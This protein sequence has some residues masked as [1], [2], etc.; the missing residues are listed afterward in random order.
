[1]LLCDIGNTSYHFFDDATGIDYREAVAAFDPASLSET[2]FYINVNADV[3]PR[4][5]ALAPWRDLEPAI[6]RR[7]YY[8]SMGIDR[9]AACEAVKEGVIIDAGSAITVDVVRGGEFEGGFITPG[10]RALRQAY[11]GISPHLGSSFNFDMP[12]DKMP[13]NTRDA[14]SYG[15]VGL[16]AARVRSFGLPIYL[17]GGDAPELAPLFDAPRLEPMLLFMGMKKII[18]KAKLC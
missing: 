14:I 4:L 17:T 12:L 8:A 10:L 11:R 15:A 9:I 5:N 2:L 7:R 1:M 3:Q 18:Q 13:K 16:L 6:D